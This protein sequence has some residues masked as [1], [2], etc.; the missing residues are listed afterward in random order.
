MKFEGFMSNFDLM[1]GARGVHAPPGGGWFGDF[2]LIF[3]FW[4]VHTLCLLVFSCWG[5]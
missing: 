2:F 5:S 3:L 1:E 4:F